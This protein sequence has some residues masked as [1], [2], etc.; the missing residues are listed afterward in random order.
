MAQSGMQTAVSTPQASRMAWPA[1]V[2]MRS[3]SEE[4]AVISAGT[5]S[6]PKDTTEESLE[7]ERLCLISEQLRGLH[8]EEATSKDVRTHNRDKSDNELSATPAPR[9]IAQVALEIHEDRDWPSYIRLH[10]NI[11]TK[12]THAASLTFTVEN[13]RTRRPSADEFDSTGTAEMRRLSADVLKIV[14]ASK[15][16]LD[17]LQTRFPHTPNIS[18][19]QRRTTWLSFPFNGTPWALG[20]YDENAEATELHHAF[21]RSAKLIQRVNVLVQGLKVRQCLESIANRFAEQSRSDPFLRLLRYPALEHDLE[22]NVVDACEFPRSQPS[23]ESSYGCWEAYF[24][25]LGFAFVLETRIQRALRDEIDGRGI[26]VPFLDSWLAGTA[27]HRVFAFIAHFDLPT[28]RLSVGTR[29]TVVFGTNALGEWKAEVIRPILGSPQNTTV[30]QISRPRNNLGLFIGNDP[31]NDTMVPRELQLRVG[32]R[33]AVMGRARAL[34]KVEFTFSPWGSWETDSIELAALQDLCPTRGLS[35]RDPYL[36]RALAQYRSLFQGSQLDA[37]GRSSLW[38]GIDRRVRLRYLDSFE[39]VLSKAQHS[40]MQ[41]ICDNLTATVGIFDGPSKAGI[42]FLALALALP[43]LNGVTIRKSMRDRF[44]VIKK[45]FFYRLDD[46]DEIPDDLSIPVNFDP[47]GREFKWPKMNPIFPAPKPKAGKRHVWMRAPVLCLAQTSKKA[48]EMCANLQDAKDR[49]PC[50]C[51]PIV[52]RLRPIQAELRIAYR[53]IDPRLRQGEA[54]AALDTWETEIEFEQFAISAYLRSLEE[55]TNRDHA[56]VSWSMGLF[57]V[58]LLGLIEMND[59]MKQRISRDKLE[60]FQKMHSELKYLTDELRAGYAVDQNEVC[61]KLK[62]ALI[63][64]F[65]FVDI[66]V[67]TLDLALCAPVANVFLPWCICVE[68]AGVAEHKIWPIFSRFWYARVRLVVGGPEPDP[69]PALDLANNP[70]ASTCASTFLARL[71]K[72]GLKMATL[73]ADGQ[74][75]SAANAFMDC[76]WGSKGRV[77]LVR[78]A[79]SS[80][81]TVELV[82]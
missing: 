82:R 81:Q 31:P 28:P 54:S 46:D 62:R 11:E 80:G 43:F 17:L 48:N 4:T 36:A 56:C 21:G 30:L 20:F 22:Y 34:R 38:A 42:S 71:K 16:P 7:K 39:K 72:T 18:E 70:L 47:Q 24:Y 55:P 25:R 60:G 65:E 52:V 49:L 51:Q 13:L 6:A 57:V 77:P 14:D 79:D 68:L 23:E 76:L 66:L 5:L 75:P 2:A 10:F 19:L 32:Q 58:Q 1:I 53:T 27:R 44:E 35:T 3:A 9:P 74:L 59:A 67:T 63:S 73:P 26:F 15:C 69:P 50:P 37:A 12:Q 40:A 78:R 33:F 41:K 61:Q 29:G 45:T 8:I 64:A